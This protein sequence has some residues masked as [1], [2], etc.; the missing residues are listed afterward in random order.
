MTSLSA[1]RFRLEDRGLV[2]EGYWADLTVFDPETI[3]DR[4]T[5]LEP[6]A[7]P[8]GIDLVVINGAVVAEDGRVATDSRAGHVV[9]RGP[10][11]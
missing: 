10:T 4:A 11:T 8:A 5:Y 7:T 3:F 9:R 1:E 2:R 6:E